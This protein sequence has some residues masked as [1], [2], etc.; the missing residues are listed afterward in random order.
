MRKNNKKYYAVGDIS[1]AVCKMQKSKMQKKK[2]MG[3]GWTRIL[4]KEMNFSQRK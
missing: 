1:P 3:W 2:G 4:Q